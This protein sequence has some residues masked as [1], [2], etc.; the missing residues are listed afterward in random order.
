M[1]QEVLHTLG[2]RKKGREGLVGIK[3]DMNKAYDHIEWKFLERVLLANR[4]SNQFC[5]LIL[6]CVSSM[7]FLLLLN[8]ASLPSFVPKKGVAA[9]RSFVTVSLYFV[10]R[11]LVTTNLDREGEG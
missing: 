1:A 5:K 9:R 2:K 4:F 6:K 7:N 11:N 10:Q 3:I 8:G